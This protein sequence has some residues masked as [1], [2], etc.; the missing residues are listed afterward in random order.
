MNTPIVTADL[1][2]LEK[3]GWIRQT[4]WVRDI[5]ELRY[6]IRDLVSFKRNQYTH[7]RVGEKKRKIEGFRTVVRYAIY[8]RPRKKSIL[9]EDLRHNPTRGWP[10]RTKCK[11]E[12]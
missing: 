5:K 8:I 3:C 7:W 2:R 11:T 9:A 12:L 6:E 10:A 1:K 4:G